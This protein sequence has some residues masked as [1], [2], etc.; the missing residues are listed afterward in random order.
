MVTT[1]TAPM[2]PSFPNKTMFVGFA[3]V[4]SIF[5]GI[6][7][8]FLVER[9]DNGFRT[10]D[11]VEKLIG[12]PTLGLVPTVQRKDVPQNLVVERPTVQYSEAIRSIRTA[13]RY[14]D[15][16]H[17]PK[18]ILITSS[19]PGEGKTVFATSFA[20]SVARSGARALLIDCDLR[21]P[22]IARI[23]KCKAEPGLLGL[24]AEDC[25]PADLIVVDEGSGMHFIPSSGGTA[26]PQ[27]LLGSQHM[28]SFLDRMRSQYDL[29][30]VDAPP[31]LAVSDPIILSHI[32][33]TTLYLVRWEKTPRQ[34]VTG[35]M[36]ILR[37][38]GGPVAG[39]VM[40]RVNARKHALYGY[41]DAG[42]YYGRYGGYYS[43]S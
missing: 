14:S 2:L 41:G 24:F 23:L 12:L 8:A 42:Y 34:V 20:R 18:V 36:K 29:I 13:L 40:S 11:Q 33:D 35:A 15:I 5:V 25:N 21:R 3:L 6:G 7:L 16:D 22:G 1:A 43:K 27:D 19:L 26:N 28:R 38:N 39:V 37:S 10:S 32:V 30:V 31:V 4:L 17:P 9:L